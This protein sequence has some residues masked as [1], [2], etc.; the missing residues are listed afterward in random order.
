MVNTSIN[1]SNPKVG[2][3]WSG[4]V[5]A[6]LFVVLVFSAALPAQAGID[7]V[8]A[9]LRS[10]LLAN[11]Q[12]P[13]QADAILGRKSLKFEA[14]VLANM[15][16]ARESKVNYKQFLRKKEVKDAQGF[17]KKHSQT[18][19]SA[20]EKSK[21]DSRVVAAIIMVESRLGRYTGGYRS[22]NVLASQAV[23][24]SKEARK[25]LG[26]YWPKKRKKEI[27]SSKNRKRF[28]RRAKWAK[29][30]L[31][32]LLRLAKEHRVSVT[33]IK[34]SPAGALG[35]AQFMPSNV[36]RYGVDATGDGKVDLSHPQDAIFSVANY[37]KQHGWKPGLAKKSRMRV[38]MTYNK[39]TPYA[40]TVLELS[41]KLKKI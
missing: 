29:A 26:T 39:S 11:G 1:I 8:F 13:A 14:K 24:D 2:R 40:R 37:L 3:A 12:S 30:E 34:G 6:L 9:P 28:S 32:A 38:I 17:L 21:V 7:P 41:Q 27:N 15:L 19:K 23:L 33:S 31:L 22:L 20:Y 36:F 4:P 16:S 35:M 5:F 25:R 18:F 10:Y